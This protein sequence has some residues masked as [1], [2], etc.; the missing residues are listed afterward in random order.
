MDILKEI[1]QELE[2]A[3]IDSVGTYRGGDYRIGLTK[4]IDIVNHKIV[5]KSESISDAVKRFF[6]RD[7]Q[8]LT[9]EEKDLKRR[10]NHYPFG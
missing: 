1:I 2:K 4:A 10:I 7:K 9:E 3:K 6:K 5:V 8:V